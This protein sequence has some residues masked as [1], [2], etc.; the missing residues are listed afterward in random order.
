MDRRTFIKNST[1]TAMS[2]SAFGS[3]QWNGKTFEGKTPTTTDILGPFYRPGSPY[4]TNL[5][6]NDSNGEIL[7]LAGSVYDRDGKTPL[8]NVLIEAWQCDENMNYDNTSE[9][10]KFRGAT[11][12]TE[13]GKYAFKTIVPVPYPDGDE[14]RPAHIHL[15]V[16]SSNYQDLITQIYIKGDQYIAQ[17]PAAGAPESISRILEIQKKSDGENIVS[18]DIVLSE[19]YALDQAGF[20]KI[21]GIYQLENG[22][23]EFIREDDLLIMKLNGQILE[24]LYYK[25][26]NSFASSK[27]F[28][29]VEFEILPTGDVKAKLTL[30]DSWTEDDRWMEVHEGIKV[31]KYKY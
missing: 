12:T 11:K 29:H 3:I 20:E 17:D 9:E 10:Y 4:R 1:L 30:W 28:N 6:P 27:H 24:A 18:F 13:D 14:W 2:I 31:F 23:A 5:I 7:H 26:N 25:G 19:S 16:S 22:M 15:R 21:T 8:S